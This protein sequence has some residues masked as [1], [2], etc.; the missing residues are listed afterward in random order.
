MNT[1]TPRRALQRTPPHLV[2]LLVPGRADLHLARG[3]AFAAVAAQGFR[4]SSLRGRLVHRRAGRSSSPSSNG[5]TRRSGESGPRP[6]RP[7]CSPVRWTV[8]AFIDRSQNLFRLAGVLTGRAVESKTALSAAAREAVEPYLL[9][10][11]AEALWTLQHAL[12]CRPTLVAS[13]LEACCAGVLQGRPEMLVAEETTARAEA[14]V[15][16][17]LI[18]TVI[19]RAGWVEL[20]HDGAL[21]PHGGIALVLNPAAAVGPVVQD[22]V[23][24]RGTGGT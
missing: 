13:G 5:W 15:V 1:A 22:E 16:E 24:E 10:R 20:A 21:E 6:P 23:D 2:L 18:E 4:S 17:D 11:E 3:D 9:S 7:R 14:G 12:V 8:T 19:Y